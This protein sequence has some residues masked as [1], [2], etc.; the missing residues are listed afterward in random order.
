MPGSAVRAILHCPLV[1]LLAVAVLSGSPGELAA[2]E[3]PVASACPQPALAPVIGP[4]PDRSGAP[5]DIR[6]EFFDARKDDLGEAIGNVELFRADQY[7]STE[8]VRYRPATGTVSVPSPLEY[9]D[10][11]IELRA[12]S[13]LF[14]IFEEKGDFND[15]EYGLVGSSARGGAERV[16]V[17]GTQRSELYNLW[18]TTCPGEDPEWVLSARELELRHEEGVGVARG[19]RLK[20]GRVP[21]LYLPWMTFPIDDRRKTGFLYPTIG[22][23]NDNGLELSIPWYWNIAPQQDA[24]LEPRWFG[25]RGFMLSSEYRLLT[26]RSYS[27]LDFDLMPD[28]RETGEER[29]RYEADWNM[30]INRTWRSGAHLERVS[31]DNFFQDFGGGLAQTA[32]QFLRSD[33][34]LSGSGRYWI[35]SALVDD[36][37]VIDDSVEPDSEP[38]SR[39]P[40]FSFLLDAPLGRSDFGARVDAEA[41]YFHRDTGVTGGRLDLFPSLLWSRQGRLGF[42][43]ASAG[44]RYTTYALDLEGATGDESPNRGVPIFSLDTGTY[45]DRVTGRGNRQT[46]EPRLYYLY[47]PFEDQ[48][49]LPDFDTGE[50]TF[51]YAQLFHSNRFTGADRQT[52]ANQVTLAATSRIVSGTTGRDLLGFTFGQILYLEPPRVTLE[53]DAPLNEDTSPLLAQLQWHPL[54]RTSVRLGIEWSW[55][56]SELNVGVA[57][58]DHR[59]K[60]GS[61]IGFGYRFRRD[62]IDQFDARF[63]YPINENWRAFT[64]VNYALDDSELLEGLIGVEYESCCWALRVSARRYLRDRNGRERTALYAELRLKGLGAFGRREPDLF[65]LSGF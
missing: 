64:R 7:L 29:W 35:F 8:V 38:Y 2:Q 59:W 53:D 28:D 12:S 22:T 1:A 10:A 20:L 48:S 30:A 50:I 45:F 56:N 54:D 15:L 17:S 36:F 6:A 14:G 61:R 43:E 42:V 51:G 57:A 40:R 23:A 26:R 32:T 3:S 55:E 19:A 47:V 33:A 49:T 34:D 18:F 37:Q 24:V 41:V 27:V 65:R 13:G 21:V 46:L 58:L 60:N 63:L 16:S 44:Y 31:D 5:I 52:D 25:E 62:R 9:R 39:L 4:I 11:Q